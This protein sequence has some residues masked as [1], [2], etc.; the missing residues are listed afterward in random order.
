M[1]CRKCKKQCCKR[2]E[3]ADFQI[4]PP[5]EPGSDQEKMK[6]WEMKGPQNEKD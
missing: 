5:F 1:S 3:P 4:E 6:E 2:D